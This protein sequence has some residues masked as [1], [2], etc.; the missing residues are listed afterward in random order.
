MI[1]VDPASGAQQVVA[2]GPPLADPTGIAVDIRAFPGHDTLLVADPEA[3]GGS[4]AL[5][6]VDPA[7]GSIQTI[8][9]GDRFVDPTGVTGFLV[10]ADPNG[11]P[12]NPDLGDGD[13]IVVRANTGTQI[14][15]FSGPFFLTPNLDLVDPSGIYEGPSG[16]LFIAD[17]EA[18]EGGAGAIFVIGAPVRSLGSSFSLVSQGG[19]LVDPTGIVSVPSG[20]AGHGFLAVADR[21]AAG[22]GAVVTLTGQ[23]GQ[24]AQAVLSNGGSFAS[25]SAIAYSPFSGDPL[26]VA[27]RAASGGGGALI[28]VGAGGAQH[29]ISSGDSFAEPAGVTVSP[30]LCEDE[31]A[32]VVG[33]EAADD[34]LASTF[35]NVIAGLGGND[36]ID[37]AESDDLVCGGDG[38]DRLRGDSG[39]PLLFGPDILLGEE[40]NDDLKGNGLPDRLD[41]GPGND[42]LRGK[43][44][45]KDR[46]DCGPGRD[47]A[48]VDR[49][50][51]VRGCE[52]V[53]VS[54]K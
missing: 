40:G 41:G 10:V 12:A 29:V 52:R 7:N 17:P 39:D 14:S 54:K 3:L 45:G 26:L 32:D 11:T 15:L 42:I 28:G 9:S 22:S 6:R 37:A 25:P 44:G 5:F 21:S 46:L 50:D 27:D 35:S 31:R 16:G 48:K 23:G 30:P 43:N 36:T 47:K 19:N 18:S 24:V 8:S 20:V 34:I 2:S 4:G 49:K 51:R 53:K 13:V 33:S 38:D 1:K